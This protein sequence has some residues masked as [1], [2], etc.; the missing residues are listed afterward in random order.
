[1]N[2]FSFT[3]PLHKLTTNPHIITAPQLPTEE[4]IARSQ[5]RDAELL[6]RLEQVSKSVSI[7]NA[8]PQEDPV[9]A[10]LRDWQM[11]S[12]RTGRFGLSVAQLPGPIKDDWGREHHIH[13]VSGAAAGMGYAGDDDDVDTQASIEAA[14]IAALGRGEMMGPYGPP[15]LNL[16]LPSC[17]LPRRRWTAQPDAPRIKPG[18]LNVLQILELYARFY[19]L[20]GPV[21]SS[22]ELATEF[23]LSEEAITALLT[24]YR[25]PLVYEENKQVVGVWTVPEDVRGPVLMM[26]DFVVQ[27]KKEK[28]AKLAEMEKE[29]EKRRAVFARVMDGVPSMDSLPQGILNS[30]S[31]KVDQT[32]D[33]LAVKELGYR[34]F[35]TGQQLPSSSSTASDRLS[36]RQFDAPPR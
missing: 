5:Q 9:F 33:H 13:I 1:M 16:A 27:K 12:V 15:R 11:D 8:S 4:E 35:D 20:R 17:E 32:S 29:E 36:S 34:Q 19:G 2:S 14:G 3:V 31:T 10:E 30:R 28:Q 6:K 7:Q 23:Q 18:R 22:A 24:N 25:V 21:P 26:G